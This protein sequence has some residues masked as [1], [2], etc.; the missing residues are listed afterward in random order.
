[1]PRSIP[2]GDFEVQINMRVNREQWECITA[3]SER[4]HLFKKELLEL[5]MYQLLRKLNLVPRDEL[6]EIRWEGLAA[7]HTIDADGPYLT[8]Q[9]LE[10]WED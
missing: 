5:G 4:S 10:E 6:A 9:P 2:E 7:S 3:L 1:M 8:T